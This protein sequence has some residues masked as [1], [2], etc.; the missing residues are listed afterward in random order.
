MKRR[1]LGLPILVATL[2]IWCTSAASGQRPVPT[3]SS[4]ISHLQARNVR[5]VAHIGGSTLDVAVQGDYL[6]A[7]EGPSLSILDIAS[8]HQD[9]PRLVSRI[10]P[11]P[12]G[13]VRSVAVSGSYAYVTAGNCLWIIDVG[14]PTDPTVVGDYCPSWFSGTMNEVAVAGNYAYLAAA[15]YGLII[16]NISDPKKPSKTG[17]FSTYAAKGVAVSGNYVYVADGTHGLRILDVSDPASPS[18]VG[19]Y[20][21]TGFWADRVAVETDYAYVA[22]GYN[23]GDETTAWDGL[24]LI[25]IADP[26][27][28]NHV[29][30]YKMYDQP[31]Y[32]YDVAVTGGLAYVVDY[33]LSRLYIVNVA[34]PTTPYGLGY[35]KTPGWAQGVA[36]TGG[37]AYIA[38]KTRGVR[39]LD[40]SDPY[41][42]TEAGSYE[43]LGTPQAVAVHWGYA[44]VADS[45]YGLRILDVHTPEKP[46]V[47]GGYATGNAV[48][49]TAVG[50][51]VY[52]VNTPCTNKCLQIIDATSPST[53]SEVGWYDTGQA[54][55][56]VVSGDHA[57][58]AGINGLSVVN[59]SDPATPTY[60]GR[61]NPGTCYAVALDSPHAYVTDWSGLHIVDISDPSNPSEA[62]SWSSPVAAMDVALEGSLAYVAA[63]GLHVVSLELSGPQEVGAY[64][65]G[66]GEDYQ[67]VAVDGFYAYVADRG[68]GLR[69]ID[70]SDPRRPDEVGY[71]TPPGGTGRGVATHL[72]YAYLAND[73]YGLF[74]LQLAPSVSITVPTSGSMLTSAPDRTTYIF[75]AGT[76]SVPVIIT[77]TFLL[78]GTPGSGNLTGIRHAFELHAVYSDTGQPAQPL[79][80]RTY[81]VTIT[82]SEA[83]KGA[84]IE[85]T[86]ALYSWDGN[87]WVEE[88][89]SRV[90]TANNKVTA[91]PGHMSLWAVLGETR[92]LYLPVILAIR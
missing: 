21:P 91:T 2:A 11:L 73:D 29:G 56:V 9:T 30:T 26:A 76:F 71:Y 8:P 31:A 19:S 51:N 12:S 90:D 36:V 70:V 55:D 68:K 61:Y 32:P 53:P 14:T 46:T 17:T 10:G 43:T 22:A 66:T 44:Y 23:V 48:N 28:P 69:V 39:V 78:A 72:G 81:T 67:S 74:I 13:L 89:T 83:E 45:S 88:T 92:R 75:P 86:L 38:D 20:A 57:Y 35:K 42:P 18:E 84:A 77:H 60:A 80:G 4:A 82:Y 79:P 52:V 33:N 37:Y 1:A 24:A 3:T 34:T 50:R 85:E 65:P 16:V 59:I 54:G 47:A 62:A 64:A 6:Y 40:V 63:G 15:D 41:T 87:R 27:S 58:V 7:G 25:H 5:L 49:V